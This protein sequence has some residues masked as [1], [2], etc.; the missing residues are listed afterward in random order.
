LGVGPG[1]L[2]QDFDPNHRSLQVAS[3]QQSSSGSVNPNVACSSS[4]QGLQT[5]A[6]NCDTV[7]DSVTLYLVPNSPLSSPTSVSDD[8]LSAI[9]NLMTNQGYAIMA[10]NN[11]I[12]GL[13][14]LG[15][16]G[17]SNNVY[18]PPPRIEG[19]NNPSSS[20]RLSG[21]GTGLIIGSCILL[22]IIAIVA[23]RRRR[24]T[25]YKTKTLYEDDDV[26]LFSKTIDM[27]SKIPHG[28]TETVSTA[29]SNWRR[30]RGAHVMGE[31]D[32][33]CAADTGSIIDDLREAESRSLY[34]ASPRAGG[35]DEDLLSRDSND[36]HRCQSA[37]CDVCAQ[38]RGLVFVPTDSTESY[39]SLC[40][41]AS[42]SYQS[43]DTVHL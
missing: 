14:F 28:D 33:V 32:S 8:T 1:R 23:V 37:T 35:L 41:P 19:N 40:S 2:N 6:T 5:A 7:D 10:S 27:Y 39:R 31:G 25:Q 12:Q 13:L 24:V 43:N 11:G 3:F 42:R 16:P 22:L 18:N 21:A 4:I 34:G 26:A 20:S 15:K 9:R 38:R 17:S 36:V 29:S 30:A